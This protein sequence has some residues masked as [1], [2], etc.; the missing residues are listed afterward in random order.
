MN[1]TP[2]TPIPDVP[3]AMLTALP[4]TQ[5]HWVQIAKNA[6]WQTT[7]MNLNTFERHGV[8]Q[9]GATVDLIADRLRNP[10]QIARAKVLPYQLMVAFQNASTAPGRIRDAL[11]DAMELATLNVPAIAGKVWV[12]PDVSGS[13]RSAITGSRKGSTSRVSCLEVAALIAASLVRRNKDA[14]VVPFSDDVLDVS[15]NARDSVMTN[16]EKLSR[17]PSGGTNCSAPLKWLNDRSQ[18]GDLLV[19]VSENESWMDNTRHGATATMKQWEVF[20]QRSPQARLVCLDLQPYGHTQARDRTDVLNIGG[21]S[22]SVFDVIA[23][24]AEGSLG[25][26]HW[27]DAVKEVEL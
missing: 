11:Q 26:R 24:F 18:R 12:F 21:F 5:A 13:M 4:L 25:G 20:R 17:L 7:R 15:L 3:M 16:A 6:S 27:V 14:G 19:Y 23:R 1:T 10:A 9:D 22:D 8:Y 2:T